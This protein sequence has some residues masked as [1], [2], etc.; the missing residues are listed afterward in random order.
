MN[1]NNKFFFQEN[2]FENA[3]LQNSGHFVQASMF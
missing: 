2:I 3:F 1:Q